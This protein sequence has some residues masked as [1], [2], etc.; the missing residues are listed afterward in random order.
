[1]GGA[2]EGTCGPLEGVDEGADAATR[3]LGALAG[4]LAASRW[5]RA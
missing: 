2:D 5:P 3:L 4:L 1:M